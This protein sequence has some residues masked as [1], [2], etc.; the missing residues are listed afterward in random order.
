MAQ[1]NNTMDII[2]ILDKSNCRECSFPTC[3]AFAAAVARG[4]KRLDECPRLGTEVIEK[5]GGHSQKE[6]DIEQDVENNIEEMKGKIRSMDF[7]SVAKRLDI[8]FSNNTLTIK[9]CGKN[10][11]VNKDGN[12]SSEIHLHQWIMGPIFNYISYSAGLVPKGEWISFRELKNGKSWY[13]F[14]VQRCEKPLKKVADTYPDL[15]HDMLHLFSGRQVENHYQSDI[16]LVLHPLPKVPI[17]ICY[18]KPEDGL[19]SGLNIFFDSTASDNLEVDYI[20]VLATGLLIMFEKIAL[21]HGG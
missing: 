21:R 17:L 14:F 19:E 4:Q 3:L 11:N 5:F 15:F 8:P 10:I 9:V 13:D 1:L 20:Y 6:S 12:F 18:W 16:S 7:A 2:K